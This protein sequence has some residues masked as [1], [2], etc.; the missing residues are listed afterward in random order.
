MGNEAGFFIANIGSSH[1]L[2]PNKCPF[3]LKILLHVP[4]I[5]KN[6][7]TVSQFSL[8]NDVFFELQYKIEQS[9]KKEK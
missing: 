2:S 9:A 4:Q 6:L 1:F 8:D 7:I 3:V 5:T